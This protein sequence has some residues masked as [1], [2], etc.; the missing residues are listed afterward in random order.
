MEELTWSMVAD[1]SSSDLERCTG[2][3]FTN[4]TWARRAASPP[5]RAPFGPVSSP[6]WA[7]TPRSGVPE[8]M[9]SCAETCSPRTADSVS[10]LVSL[11]SMAFIGYLGTRT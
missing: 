3:Y 4:R 1:H 8:A 2:T 11:P 7:D 6:T 9:A 5:S 10:S